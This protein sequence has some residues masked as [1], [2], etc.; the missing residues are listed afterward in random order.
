M[1]FS[2]LFLCLFA[3][4]H[5]SAPPNAVLW[6]LSGPFLGDVQNPCSTT[7]APSTCDSNI[8][9]VR[10]TDDYNVSSMFSLDTVMW[11]GNIRLNATWKNFTEDLYV[12]TFWGNAVWGGFNPINLTT[13][14]TCNNWTSTSGNTMVYSL[15]NFNTPY[16][17]PCGGEGFPVLCSCI[18]SDPLR[19]FSPSRNP[20]VPTISP[21]KNPSKNPTFPTTSPSKNPSA[22]PTTPTNS[23]SH[24]P[25]KNPTIAPFLPVIV[26]PITNYTN[27]APLACP[28]PCPVTNYSGSAINDPEWTYPSLVNVTTFRKYPNATEDFY[29]NG[30]AV[31]N[32]SS[33]TLQNNVMCFAQP[34]VNLWLYNLTALPCNTVQRKQILGLNVQNVTGLAVLN[35][36]NVFN[37]ILLE[38]LPQLQTVEVVF[39]QYSSVTLYN[40]P[41]LREL[42]LQ[43]LDSRGLGLFQTYGCDSLPYI[44]A[45]SYLINGIQIQQTN[46]LM[47]IFLKGF[48]NSALYINEA[49]AFERFDI[50]N[51]TATG[52][53]VIINTRSERFLNSRPNC[54]GDFTNNIT[55]F[56]VLLV[57]PERPSKKPHGVCP[58]NRFQVFLFFGV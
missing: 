40:T 54:I 48:G 49:Y 42:N 25:S 7:P 4:A 43:V 51:T 5:A 2:L 11:R 37:G 8:R 3:L 41:V 45:S 13:Y 38:N 14:G 15:I 33:L 53:A 24:N 57:R 28:T 50:T 20:T 47:G 30:T 58:T 21:S 18:S 19:T 39:E 23:P 26:Q 46:N 44:N 32:S 31:R 55:F 56:I 1:L 35:D 12:D 17:V 9:A 6:R 10:A 16:I 27:A 36:T 34:S 22:N 29:Q 52:A